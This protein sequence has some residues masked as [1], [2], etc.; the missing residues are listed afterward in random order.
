MFIPLGDNVEKRAFPAV[1][2]ILIALNCFVYIHTTRL[3]LGGPPQSAD[4]YEADDAPFTAPAPPPAYEKFIRLWGLVPADLAKGNIL[5][6]LTYMFL[7]GDFFH[8]LGNMLMLWALVGSLEN[9]LGWKA[10][11]GYYLLWGVIAGVTHA[12]LSWGETTPMIGAS[13]AVSGMIGAYFIAFGALSK[14]RT[15]IWIGYPF[16]VDVPATLFVVVWGAQQLLGLS[17]AIE[18][19]VTGIAWFAHVGGFAA[20]ALTMHL[21]RHQTQRR[22]VT[23]RG[24]ELLFEEVEPGVNG[25][26][27]AGQA[28]EAA[29]A[30]PVVPEAP[31]ANCPHCGTDLNGQTKIHDLLLRCPKPECNRLIFLRSG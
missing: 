21:L 9:L 1:G 10:F 2:I 18:E 4:A 12:V 29:E 23:G 15:L 31:P 19:G 8:V 20:G 11:L 14:I 5:S 7:H 13:G 26:T 30:A 22:L 3:L 27:E 24:G 25:P 28:T 6:L 17:D 16:K